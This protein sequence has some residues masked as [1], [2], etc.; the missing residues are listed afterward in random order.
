MESNESR[1]KLLSP[2]IPLPSHVADESILRARDRCLTNVHPSILLRVAATNQNRND[3]PP[4]STTALLI[5]LQQ[6]P[7]PLALSSALCRPIV[8]RHFPGEARSRNRATPTHPE[9]RQAAAPSPTPSRIDAPSSSGHLS[10]VRPLTLA[11]SSPTSA[12]R[13]KVEQSKPVSLSTERVGA[14]HCEPHPNTLY[15]FNFERRTRGV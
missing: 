13:G 1:T 9:P 8:T 2:V 7:H 3:P 10:S 6:I 5:L 15:L 4:H 11:C 12:R 14:S